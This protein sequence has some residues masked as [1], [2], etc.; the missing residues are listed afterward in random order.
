VDLKVFS[1]VSAPLSSS[2]AHGW[3]GLAQHFQLVRASRSKSRGAGWPGER[4][5]ESG[6]FPALLGTT[7]L[8]LRPPPVPWSG[9]QT[10]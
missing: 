9:W 4:S 8:E 3:T 1:L 10:C 7:P 2:P 5:W 6:T